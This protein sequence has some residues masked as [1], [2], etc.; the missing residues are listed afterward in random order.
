MVSAINMLAS[1]CVHMCMCVHVCVTVVYDEH[2]LKAY[3]LAA[4]YSDP[5]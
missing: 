4:I 2:Y 1:V 3:A 5:Y